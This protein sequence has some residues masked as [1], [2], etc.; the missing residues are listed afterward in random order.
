MRRLPLDAR[1]SYGDVR[2]SIRKVWPELESSQAR[3]RDD[4]GDMCTLCPASFEDFLFLAGSLE[5]APLMLRLE[6]VEP[7]AETEYDRSH[8]R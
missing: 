5:D 4:E 3:Y 6:F 7:R 8:A 1:P 2:T